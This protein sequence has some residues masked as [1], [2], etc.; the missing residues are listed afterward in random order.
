[1]LETGA[2]RLLDVVRRGGRVEVRTEHALAGQVE[3]A[4]VL[5][6]GAGSDLTEALATQAETCDKAVDDGG[7][8]VL[9]GGLQV[10]AARAG[11]RNAVA[12][13]DE[14]VTRACGEA[15]G[16]LSRGSIEEASVELA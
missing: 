16:G 9:V 2:A 4:R 6:D 5:D 3:V 1:M 11:E 15:H 7:Q 8:H 10:L 14:N 13:E 12:A